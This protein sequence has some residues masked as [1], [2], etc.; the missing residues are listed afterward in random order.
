MRPDYAYGLSTYSIV[1]ADPEAG[2]CGVAVQSKFLAVGAFVPWARGGIGAVATQAHA[3]ITYGNRGLEM[4]ESG[5]A[6]DAVIDRLTSDDQMRSHRQVGIVSADGSSATY[7]GE[8]CFD[9]ECAT[10]RTAWPASGLASQ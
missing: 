6:P 3:E 10:G 2:E 4:L 7:T 1:G 5:V 8:D 9:S